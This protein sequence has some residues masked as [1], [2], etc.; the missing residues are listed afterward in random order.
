MH[1][2]V[3]EYGYCRLIRVRFETVP[4]NSFMRLFFPSNIVCIEIAFIATIL[5]QLLVT[6]K[7][8]KKKEPPPPPAVG[9]WIHKLHVADNG[10]DGLA[11]KKELAPL[12]MM[13]I[14]KKYVH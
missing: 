9:P 3:N 13:R 4:A 12:Q 5:K 6:G 1:N 14:L 7:K 2:I 10:I 11:F 8:K